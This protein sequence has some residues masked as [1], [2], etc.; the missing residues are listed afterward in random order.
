MTIR[1]NEAGLSL[2][3][4]VH[5]LILLLLL[6]VFLVEIF[7]ILLGPLI[8]RVHL[9]VEQLIVLTERVSG[10]DYVALLANAACKV[11][12]GILDDDALAA[13]CIPL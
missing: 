9:V 3:F 4:F 5:L 6:N 13:L 2:F 10:S 1:D 11:G 7:A 12:M 8:L